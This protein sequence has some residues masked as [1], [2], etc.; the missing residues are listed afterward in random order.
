MVLAEARE[1]YQFE[2]QVLP[3]YQFLAPYFFVVTGAE[4]NL[5]VFANP[6]VVMLAAVLTVLGILGKLI[7]GALGAWGAST[8][9]LLGAAIVGVGMVPRGEVGLI[10]AGIGRSRGVIP[11]DIF[12]AVVI[13]SIATTLVAP[14]LLTW[15]YRRRLAAGRLAP[16]V[17][18]PGP[19]TPTPETARV[20]S[21]E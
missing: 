17:E 8:P 15:L 1:Q 13:M 20:A 10:V 12:S 16:A 4:V 18:R 3:L 14:P 11:D 6:A 9:R 21:S 2:R 5:Q 7:G 19:P